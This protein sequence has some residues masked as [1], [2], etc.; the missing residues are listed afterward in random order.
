MLYLSSPKPESTMKNILLLLGL[1]MSTLLSAQDTDWFCNTDESSIVKRSHDT[2]IGPQKTLTFYP[3]ETTS[4]QV[5]IFIHSDSPFGNPSYQ[6]R[7]SKNISK[8]TN[9][10]TVAILRPGYTDNCD[11]LSEGSKGLAMGDNYSYEN[12]KAIASIISSI[13]KAEKSTKIVVMG[14]SGG[15]A[16][17]ALLAESNPELIDQCILISCPCNLADWR[18]SMQELTGN[19]EWSKPMDG[20][21]PIDGISK[22]DLNNKIHLYVGEDDPV[23]PAFLSTEFYNAVNKLGASVSMK[24]IEGADHDSILKPEHLSM[25]LKESGLTSK[26]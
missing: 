25:I 14:H 23:T 4:T 9:S 26:E 7:I 16:L 15:A 19:T 6:Y 8:I 24:I 11:D 3:S 1:L 2:A 12:V 5:I 22:L 17:A 21:S 10:I 13:K 18:T 20:L